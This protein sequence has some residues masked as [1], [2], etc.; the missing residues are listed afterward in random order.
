MLEK[1]ERGRKKKV[2]LGAEVC[3]EHLPPLFSQRGEL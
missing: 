3:C 1:G 2:R